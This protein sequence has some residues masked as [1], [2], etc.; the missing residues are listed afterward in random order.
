MSERLY[1]LGFSLAKGFGPVRVQRLLDTF[2]TLKSAW[3]AS[4]NALQQAGIDQRTLKSFDILRSE[5]NLQGEMERLD[6][7]GIALLT[8]EDEAYPQTLAQLRHIDHAPHVL[9]VRGTLAEADNWALA[10]VGT[11]SV[12]AYGRQVTHQLTIELARQG[13]TIVS[14]LARGVDAVAHQAALEAG[15]RTLAVL[16]CGLDTIYPPENRRLAHQIVRHGA[17][18]SPFPLGIAPEAKNFPPR[19]RIMS[20]LAR[21][22]LV[23]EAGEKSGALSTA[24]QALEQGR[25]VFAVPGNITAKGSSG[26]NSLIQD[27]ANP[28]LSARDILDVL[29]VEYVTEYV[30]AR[31]ALPDLDATETQILNCLDTEPLHI[32]D[33]THRSKLQ[34]AVVSTALMKL[35]LKGIVREV[36]PMTFARSS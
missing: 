35:Q 36:G 21:G 32:D 26:T 7:L 22:V 27:G 8:W 2:G 24:R 10:V 6:T 4:T 29:D 20:G 18:I 23:T 19:N 1:W 16:G 30:S 13:V 34:S 25:E 33:I 5:V 17:L 9:Y 3:S 31:R 12:S 14:G 11:R 15:S 28:V